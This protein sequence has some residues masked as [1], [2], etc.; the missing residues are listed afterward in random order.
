MTPSKDWGRQGS[1]PGSGKPKVEHKIV[2]E[3]T[4]RNKLEAMKMSELRSYVKLH[5]LEAKDTDKKELIDE[6]IKEVS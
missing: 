5:S 6:I 2:E 1:W 4:L 3:D